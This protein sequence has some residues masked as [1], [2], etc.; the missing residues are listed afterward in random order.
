MTP[1]RLAE[2]YDIHNRREMREWE[3]AAF[4]THYVMAAFIGK[5]A[6]SIDRLL[7]RVTDA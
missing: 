2:L 4:I 5:H 7:G 6:P 3:R 1:A